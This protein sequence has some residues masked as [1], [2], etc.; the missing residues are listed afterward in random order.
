[1][2]GREGGELEG[3]MGGGQ[4]SEGTECRKEGKEMQE[5]GRRK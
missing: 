4:I 1:M 5:K 3:G 2:D